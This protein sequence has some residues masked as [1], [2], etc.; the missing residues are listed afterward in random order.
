MSISDI[1]YIPYIIAYYPTHVV[2]EWQEIK[3]HGWN[4]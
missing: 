1:K 3:T 4:T 2:V